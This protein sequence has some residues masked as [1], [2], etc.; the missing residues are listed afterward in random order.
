MFVSL[1][2]KRTQWNKVAPEIR[3]LGVTWS[4]A[5][6]VYAYGHILEELSVI[7]CLPT[8]Q[9]DES[10]PYSNVV[11]PNRPLRI[12]TQGLSRNN[13]NNPKFIKVSL[14]CIDS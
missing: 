7:K 3:F 9:T 1:Q 14:A 10:N 12:S 4:Q 5:G 6:D 11:V 13:D 8:E 2:R